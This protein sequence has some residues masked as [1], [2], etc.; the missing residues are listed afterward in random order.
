MATYGKWSCAYRGEQKSL[1]ANKVDGVGICF[2]TNFGNFEDK[3]YS[4]DFLILVN[5]RKKS[6][7]ISG[8][9]LQNLF[10]QKKF[11]EISRKLLQN[12]FCATRVCIS[13][14]KEYLLQN[15]Q[16]NHLK[17]KTNYVQSFFQLLA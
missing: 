1:F 12:F 7:D 8:K 6:K 14:I 11:K 3:E 4:K 13:I 17:I 16:S 10:I 15:I 5:I 2:L 9:L